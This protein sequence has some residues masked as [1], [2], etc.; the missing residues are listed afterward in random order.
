[1]NKIQ[2]MKYLKVRMRI[3]TKRLR[4]CY[5]EAGEHGPCWVFKNCSPVF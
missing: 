5:D 1:M 2:T 3:R 4:W